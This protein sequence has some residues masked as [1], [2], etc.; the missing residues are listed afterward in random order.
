MFFK[1]KKNDPLAP[2]QR[3]IGKRCEVV[4]SV[5]NKKGTGCVKIKNGLWAARA[6]DDSSYS[7]GESL[8]VVSNEGVKLICKR[9]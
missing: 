2:V 1:R 9:L 5:D 7:V 4:E 6:L 3:L 8:L